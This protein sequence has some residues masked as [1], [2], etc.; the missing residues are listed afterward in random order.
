MRRLAILL[1]LPSCLA[2]QQ[3]GIEGIAVHSVTGQALS[4]VHMR[5]VT[6]AD[7]NNVYGATSDSAGRFSISGMQPGVYSV[8]SQKTGFVFPSTSITIKAGQRLTDFR[9]PMIPRAVIT[10]RVLDENGV[11]IAN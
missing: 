7:V 6:R 11:P 2:A 1:L 5:V 9:V 10:A 3:A 8:Q 4:G